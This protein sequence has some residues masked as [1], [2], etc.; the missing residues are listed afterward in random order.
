MMRLI[1]VSIFWAS[2]CSSQGLP[3]LTEATNHFL[4]EHV[5]SGMVDYKAIHQNPSRIQQLYEQ[6][7]S[8]SLENASDAEKKAFYINAYNILTIYQIVQNYPVKSPTDVEGFFDNTKHQVAGESLTL[9]QVEKE[10]LM[11]N[12]FDPRLHFVLVCAAKSCPPLASFAF[13]ADQLDEQLD[14]RTREALNNPDF[15]RVNKNQKKVEVSQIFEW[16]KQ[17]FTKETSSILAYINQYRD[18]EIPSSYQVNFYK[19]DWALNAQ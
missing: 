9:D 17:D 2:S 18:E 12:H 11:K 4:E 19:Y 7:G 1:I 6:I 14:E 15:I 5:E 3:E 8:T 10:R 16:Y 13:Q